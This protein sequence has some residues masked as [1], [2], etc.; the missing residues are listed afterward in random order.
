MNAAKL[1][2]AIYDCEV[3]CRIEWFWD[4]GFQWALLDGQVYP[5]VLI[6]DNTEG[7]TQVIFENAE[8]TLLRCQPL[9]EVDWKERGGH[10]DFDTAVLQMAE[11]VIRAYPLCAETLRPLMA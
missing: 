3:N 5:R 9:P 8:G 1:I 7:S 11:A 4:S 10:E 6:D 2:K